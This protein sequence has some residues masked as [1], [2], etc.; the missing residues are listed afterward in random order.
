[1]IVTLPHALGSN[2]IDHSPPA[3]TVNQ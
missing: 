1:L 3:I 2:E